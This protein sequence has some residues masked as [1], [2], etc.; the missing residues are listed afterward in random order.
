MKLNTILLID[1]DE[2]RK[3]VF[4]NSLREKINF[5]YIK[6]EAIYEALSVTFKNTF[7]MGK[8]NNYYIFLQRYLKILSE[9]D[10]ISIIDVNSLSEKTANILASKNPNIVIIYLERKIE[11]GNYLSVDINN[12]EELQIVINELKK[13]S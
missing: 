4:I 13:R 1:N 3:E 2:S 11:K 7:N 6:L 8:K 10:T 12:L 9:K 5:S